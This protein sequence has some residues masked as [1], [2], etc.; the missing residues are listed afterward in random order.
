MAN[1]NPENEAFCASLRSVAGSGGVPDANLVVYPIGKYD[2][3][4]TLYVRWTKGT[5]ANTLSLGEEIGRCERDDLYQLLEPIFTDPHRRTKPLVVAMFRN[6]C[7]AI[8]FDGDG[9]WRF[10]QGSDC[11]FKRCGPLPILPKDSV[12]A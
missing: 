7:Q 1:P 10:V 8:E 5:R 9:K 4:D 11:E 2:L 3:L 6:K 12:Q